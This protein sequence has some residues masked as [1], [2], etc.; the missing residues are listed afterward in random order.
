VVSSDG[1]V[2]PGVSGDKPVRKRASATDSGIGCG[3]L[4]VARHNSISLLQA[5][6]SA[7]RGDGASVTD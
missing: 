7:P 2:E 5:P 3:L 4:P 1:I 6:N